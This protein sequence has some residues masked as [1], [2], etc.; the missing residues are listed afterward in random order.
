MELMSRQLSI[1]GP[2][3]AHNDA[4]LQYGHTLPP[5]APPQPHRTSA[6]AL[7][8]AF[9]SGCSNVP[10]SIVS[11]EMRR[12]KWSSTRHKLTQTFAGQMVQL[13]HNDRR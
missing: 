7:Q 9:K 10:V 2:S 3:A 13:F 4:R 12:P 1:C 8:R 6:T 11:E 5:A